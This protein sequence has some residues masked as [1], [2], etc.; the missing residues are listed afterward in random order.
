MALTQPHGHI[1]QKQCDKHCNIRRRL[2]RRAETLKVWL[3]IPVF[4]AGMFIRSV[5]VHFIL[6]EG[7]HDIIV[8]QHRTTTEEAAAGKHEG[9]NSLYRTDTIM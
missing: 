1:R 6:P 7:M 8:L 2:Y 3:H 5:K 4:A 9:L